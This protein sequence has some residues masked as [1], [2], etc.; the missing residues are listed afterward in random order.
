MKPDSKAPAA[1]L[2]KECNAVWR[3]KSE[4][5]RILLAKEFDAPFGVD[6]QVK[7]IPDPTKKA[8]EKVSFLK[9]NI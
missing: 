3:L 7:R 2:C 6:G 9:L 1:L 4:M 8:E 5:L